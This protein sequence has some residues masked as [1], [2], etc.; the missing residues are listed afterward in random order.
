M[1]SCESPQYLF[2]G[3]STASPIAGSLLRPLD[4]SS[5]EGYNRG[6]TRYAKTNTLILRVVRL[7]QTSSEPVANQS[8]LTRTPRRLPTVNIRTPHDLL[9]DQLYSIEWNMDQRAALKGK[10]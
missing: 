9:V 7:K 1:P 4:Y 10:A 6:M 2:V 3:R 8:R 5:I